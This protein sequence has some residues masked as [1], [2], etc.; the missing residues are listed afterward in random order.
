MAI[1]GIGGLGHLG[2]QY[3]AKMGFNTVAIARGQ[4]KAALAKKLGAHTYIDSTT[5]DVAD[6]LTKL[7]GAKVILATATDAK[8]MSATINGLGVDGKLVVLGASQEPIQCLHLV[9]QLILTTALDP[10]L[11]TPARRPT[12]RTR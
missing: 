1:L 9:V 5:T 10:R 12:Q 3:A 4:D 2:V 11:A 6:A 7:G 8:A